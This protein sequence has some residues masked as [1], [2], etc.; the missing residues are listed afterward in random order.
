MPENGIAVAS[1]ATQ[2]GIASNER[3]AA[4]KVLLICGILSSLLYAA[5]NAFIPLWWPGYSLASRVVSELSAVG[6][7]TRAI[8]VPL[9][10]VW[11]VLMTAFGW[12]VWRSAGANRPLRIAGAL[13]VAYGL[14]DL[15]PWPPMHQREVLAVGG[16]TLTDTLHLVWSA[17]AILFMTTAIGFGAGAL[18]R[19]FRIYSIATLLTLVVFGVLVWRDSPGVQ[20]N[21]PTPWIG[22]W[23]RINVGVFLVWVVVLAIALLRRPVPAAWF[24]LSANAEMGSGSE[25]SGGAAP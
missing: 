9:G 18:G 23:E 2:L 19:G 11:A 14:F 5:M 16:G 10:V 25:G 22:V 13:L 17:V 12:G 1:L 20:A 6:A 8:W 21:L 4:H 3:S 24:P 7:P 15:I